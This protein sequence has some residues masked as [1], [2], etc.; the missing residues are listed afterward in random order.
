MTRTRNQ[1]PQLYG[2]WTRVA[3]RIRTAPR[4]V[5]FLDFDGTLA[6]LTKEPRKAKLSRATRDAL[7]TLARRQRARLFFISGR[8]RQDLRKRV[9]LRRCE[10]LGLFG[11]EDSART[12]LSTSATMQRVKTEIEA[13]IGG[14]PGVWVE[15]KGPG[16]VLHY[17]DAP[18]RAR[19][20]AR[21]RLRTAL[22]SAGS[23]IHRFENAHGLDV[24]PREVRGKGAVIR[25]L[26]GRPALRRALPI[27]L[28]DD[29]SDESA[30]RAV[31]RGV[32]VRVGLPRP[33]A[34][35]YTL[36]NPAEVCEFLQLLG[37]ALR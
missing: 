35:R 23:E 21:R 31:R 22:D 33:T 15:D 34:A 9:R 20:Q 13:S 5:L 7:R 18:A 24:V 2:W 8:R 4:C 16:F 25:Q 26:L 32:T 3:Q 14:L 37:V 30:F 17:R 11:S 27:Y 10:Y 6:E 28:G 12:H 36:R 19:R 29:L 1:R